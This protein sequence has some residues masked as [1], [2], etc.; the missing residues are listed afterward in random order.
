M[1]ETIDT[2]V[3][4][5]GVVGLAIGRA[6]ACAGR[7]VIVIDKNARIGE[8]TS[9]RNSEV[10]HAGIYYPTGSLK[11]RLCVEGKQL[12]YRYCEQK[13]IDHRACGKV[14]V[15]VT[16]EQRRGLEA[17]KL[18]AE[19]N[20][21]HDLEWLGGDDLATLEPHVIG[22]AG[23]LS[24][25]TGIIDSHGYL[26]AL[27]ADLER[28]GGSV[29]VCSKFLEGAVT[30]DG[31]ELVIDSGGE[32]TRLRARMLVNAGGLHASA[33]ARAL[34]GLPSEHVPATRYAKG[35][36]FNYD[37][38]NPFRHLVYPLPEA[39]GLGVHATL[40][41]SGRLRFGPDVEWVERIDYTIDPARA[42]TF[43]R[44][45]SAYW[46]GIRSG[47][48]T[49]G[50]VGVRPKVV[51]PGEPAGDFVISGPPD[52]GAPGVVNLF[53]IESPGL[54]ASLAIAEHVCALTG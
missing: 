36:Y 27:Q 54:T 38:P 13:G 18:Q 43:L 47:A 7:D 15:A 16:A 8:E 9:S 14:I 3:I 31:V 44:A 41:L 17:L 39:G 24:P 46:P 11:A 28:A 23:L 6:L 34:V 5:A 22:E 37:G 20:G 25:S 51:G 50:H 48:L 1:A 4:G 40:D 49:P 35:S 2:V 10:I 21:V 33:V 42:E 32:T 30:K 53:G 26:F 19:A 45:V 12:L 52:H 29:A